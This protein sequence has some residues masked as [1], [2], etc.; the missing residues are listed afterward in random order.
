MP[1][2]TITIPAGGVPDVD[3]NCTNSG[4][5]PPGGDPGATHEMMLG[6]IHVAP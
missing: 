6:T 4:C 2:I 5:T 1:P 3:F